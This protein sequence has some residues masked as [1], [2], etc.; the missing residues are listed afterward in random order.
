M[1]Y[2]H[3]S[4]CSKISGTGPCGTHHFDSLFEDQDPYELPG[5]F[6]V[7]PLN[8]NSTSVGSNSNFCQRKLTWGAM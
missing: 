4:T 6:T 5:V 2:K 7:L 3:P 1:C 8:G